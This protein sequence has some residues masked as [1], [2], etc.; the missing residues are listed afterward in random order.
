MTTT[1]IEDLE[2]RATRKSISLLTYAILC[3]NHHAEV[4]VNA[5]PIGS[6]GDDWST[7]NFNAIRTRVFGM[8]CE[9]AQCDRVY[10]K[11]M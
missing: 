7:L 4:R 5:T 9:R 10:R 2:I 1:T 3:A 11:D 8:T 6:F